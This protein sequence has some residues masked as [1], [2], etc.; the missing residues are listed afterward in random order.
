MNIRGLIGVLILFLSIHENRRRGKFIFE[1]SNTTTPKLIISVSLLNFCAV[2]HEKSGKTCVIVVD[3]DTENKTA[4][5]GAGASTEMPN[6]NAASQADRKK[7]L[8]KSL[9]E[10]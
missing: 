6:W 10:R 1:V 2:T 8:H 7:S 9:V 5:L 4:Q 3:G